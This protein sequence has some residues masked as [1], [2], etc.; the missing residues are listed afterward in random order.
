MT[1][2]RILVV[3]PAWV[4]DMVMAQ[5]LFLLLRARWPDRE[6]DVIA[7]P[8]TYPLLARMPEVAQA[9]PL[10]APHGRLALRHRLALGWNLRP[11]RYEQAL[12][13]PRSYKSA[14]PA[15]TSG[16]RRRTGFLGEARWGLLND[17]RHEPPGHKMR[18]VDRF[19]ML[20]LEPDE[21]LPA[22]IPPRLVTDPDGGYA[23]LKRLGVA[24]PERVLALC[25]GAEYG[26]AKRWPARHFATLA[27]N[28]QAQGWQ[29]WL[30]GGPRDQEAA[31]AVQA[32]S[33]SACVD[34]TGRTTLLEAVDLLGLATAVVSNDSGLMHVAAAMGLPLVAVFGSSDPEHTPPLDPRA[35]ALSLR[36]SCS[37]CFARHC[38]LGHLQCLEGLTPER[39]EQAIQAVLGAF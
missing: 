22:V 10:L 13:L 4:G 23:V 19:L 17:I 16:A 20:G 36:L 3:G 8:A 6:L 29:I 31:Q 37:P 11:R 34:L 24:R 12:V 28:Y 33:E 39:V 7:P 38:P 25:P 9:V 2:A 27:K 15:W 32:L 30:M 21:S 35:I 5:S 18:T 26:P 14:L 1:S